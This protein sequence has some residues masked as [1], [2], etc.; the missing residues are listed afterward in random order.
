MFPKYL[1][2]KIKVKCAFEI[3]F[4]IVSVALIHFKSNLGMSYSY[5]S[6]SVLKEKKVEIAEIVEWH[7]TRLLNNIKSNLKLK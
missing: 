5:N 3:C 2:R 1:G 4:Y 7:C 6:Y